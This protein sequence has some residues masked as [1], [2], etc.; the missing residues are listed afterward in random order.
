MADTADKA[1]KLALH[2]E[3]KANQHDKDLA[4]QD[5]RLDGLGN[6]LD[7]VG[8]ELMAFQNAA[9]Q[10]LKADEAELKALR[11]EIAALKK[12]HG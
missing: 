10:R 4:K 5:K 7:K 6:F 1:W 2:V 3:R 11:A 8:R 9:N 12:A